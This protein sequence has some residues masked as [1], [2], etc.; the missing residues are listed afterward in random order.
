MDFD[1]LFSNYGLMA[2]YLKTTYIYRTQQQFLGIEVVVSNGLVEESTL[3]QPFDVWQEPA[4]RER[5]DSVEWW[6]SDEQPDL[7]R[8]YHVGQRSFSLIGLSSITAN[9]D[10]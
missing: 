1:P 3:L 5:F 7:Y 8:M 10:L 9:Y 6:S 2:P 4:A